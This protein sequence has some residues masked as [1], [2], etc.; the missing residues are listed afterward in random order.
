MKELDLGGDHA[1]IG[2]EGIKA[3]AEMLKI[4][5]SLTDLN[6]EDDTLQ[7]NYLY[8]IFTGNQIGDEGAKAVGE[9]LTANRSLIKLKLNLANKQIKMRE[10]F[11]GKKE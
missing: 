5:T 9:S 2:A 10:L 3:I 7:Y 6:L 8:F 11:I 4:N 1:N